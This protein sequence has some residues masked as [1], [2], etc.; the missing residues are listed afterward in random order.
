MVIFMSKD[1]EKKLKN[2]EID[3]EN[4]NISGG[5]HGGCFPGH[6]RPKNFPKHW[7][8]EKP[9]GHRGWGPYNQKMMLPPPPGFEQTDNPTNESGPVASTS[10]STD[11]PS[12]SESSTTSQ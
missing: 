5:C 8:K 10:P 12:S 2:N 7:G 9:H 4:E 6:K 11:L 3:V 1:K